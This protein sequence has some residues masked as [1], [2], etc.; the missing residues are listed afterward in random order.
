MRDT[1]EHLDTQQPSSHYPDARH[2][3][4]PE[5][6]WEAHTRVSQSLMSVIGEK[7]TLSS[8]EYQKKFMHTIVWAYFSVWWDLSQDRARYDQ[9][10]RELVSLTEKRLWEISTIRSMRLLQDGIETTE[11]NYLSSTGKTLLP[12]LRVERVSWEVEMINLLDTYT[13]LT[14][15]RNTKEQE[16]IAKSQQSR[17][18]L[19]E[20]IG[21]EPLLNGSISYEYVIAWVWALSWAWVLKKLRYRNTEGKMQEV[22][23]SQNIVG[24]KDQIER[25]IGKI[26]EYEGIV[27]DPMSGTWRR[28]YDDAIRSLEKRIPAMLRE[29]YRSLTWHDVQ[30]WEWRGI[31]KDMLRSLRERR[32]SGWKT[33]QS[34]LWRKW[35]L[36][37]LDALLASEVA[38]YANSATMISATTDLSMFY[39]GMKMTKPLGKWA[40]KIPL[41]GKLVW[42]IIESGG[43]AFVAGMASALGK[44]YVWERYLDGNI[45]KWKYLHT[46]EA[47]SLYTDGQSTTL[48]GLS[49]VGIPEMWDGANNTL[50]DTET[51]PDIGIPRWSVSVGRFHL[52]DIP[53]VNIFQ[54]RIDYATDPGDWMRGG[55]LRTIDDWNKQIWW[56]IGPDGQYVEWHMH[57]TT[58]RIVRWVLEKYQKWVYPFRESDIRSQVENITDMKVAKEKILERVFTETLSGWNEPDKGFLDV[59]WL[60]IQ[61]II[62]ETK[63]WRWD[64]SYDSIAQVVKMQTAK[65]RIDTYFVHQYYPTLIA[66][67]EHEIGEYKKDLYKHLTEKERAYIDTILWNMIKNKPLF[68]PAQFVET[69]VLGM[70]SNKLV[71]S[72]EGKIYQG[73]LANN[74]TV[75]ELLSFIK[76][77]LWWASWIKEASVAT[78]FSV[79]LNKFLEQKRR[80]EFLSKIEKWNKSWL[81]WT[82]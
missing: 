2:F 43:W 57:L 15:P 5:R 55:R 69:E 41:V 16:Q 60:I 61:S 35:V 64:Q 65:M 82:K 38:T 37:P 63:N 75:P 56:Y 70:S 25:S 44:W 3:S 40:R 74:K 59:K 50:K 29:E 23:P 10:I 34:L 26:L 39:L 73:L 58:M 79:L 81:Q 66:Y 21:Q 6:K 27:F 78:V 30:E 28:V 53:E 13:W 31:Q 68:P 67:H 76:S 7:S 45:K 33:F 36:L 52:F 8:S 20:T 80:I 32:N 51:P 49:W 42:P 17:L 12:I 24:T 71:W 62:K 47:W 46:N 4:R 18:E 77:K 54:W 11:Q 9:I 14:L 1:H 19:R 22:I 72:E 48:H